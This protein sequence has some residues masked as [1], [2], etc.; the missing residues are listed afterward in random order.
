MST[1]N[2]KP[3]YIVSVARLTKNARSLLAANT[4]KVKLW[5]LPPTVHHNFEAAQECFD[6]A[7]ETY[8]KQGKLVNVYNDPNDPQYTVIDLTDQTYIVRLTE[9]FPED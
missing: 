5:V 1:K 4:R 9:D 2:Q 6:N 8:S 3:M 7:V